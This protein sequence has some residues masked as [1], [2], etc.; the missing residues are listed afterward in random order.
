MAGFIL[1]RCI[2][3]IIIVVIT[4]FLIFT[5]LYF[6]PANPTDALLGQYAT[7]EEKAAMAAKLGIDRPYLVQLG[8]YMYTTFIRFDFGNSWTYGTPVFQELIVRM[9]RTLIIGLS[10]MVINLALGLSLGI[11]AGVHAGRWEDS[12]VMGIAM[13]FI[14]SPNFWV[15]L[16]MIILFSS[17]LN[18]LPPYGIGSWQCYI[19]PIIASAITGIAVNARF[20]R[21]SI[22]E[23]LRAD[24]ITT[25][26]A[27]GLRERAVIFRHML[28][29]AL[30]PT[31]TNI[32]RILSAIIAGSPVIESVFSIPGVGMYLL[33][34]IN[35]RDYPAVRACVLF[36]VVFISIIMLCVDLAYAAVDPRIKAKFITQHVT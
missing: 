16:M 4:A 24:Y 9:P 28:P 27:K 19:M 15:A 23:V 21:N 25:A 2:A 26:R 32:G 11:Y 17:V 10:A 7:L 22:V 5:I 6:T 13:L 14:A 29:N 1:K 36:F 31:I 35:T 34:A 3:T 18:W 33:T 8:D 30:M 20:G 12:V